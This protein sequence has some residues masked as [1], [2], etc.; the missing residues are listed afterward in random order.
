MALV[1]YLPAESATVGAE[2]AW[3]MQVELLAAIV[4]ELDGLMRLTY[5]AAAHKR[6]PWRPVHVRRP[7]PEGEGG[8]LARR[9]PTPAEMIGVLAGGNGRGR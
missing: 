3:A 6:A 1:R 8:H 9:E 4:E 2:G 5:Q 7:V